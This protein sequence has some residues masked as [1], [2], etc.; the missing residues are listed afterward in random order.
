MLID[1][2]DY[3]SRGM[4]PCL[5]FLK[6][7]YQDLNSIPNSQKEPRVPAPGGLTP[8]SGLSGWLHSQAKLT[9]IHIH[10]ILKNNLDCFL[11]EGG[12]E[13]ERESR[14]SSLKQHLPRLW[15]HPPPRHQ[16][17]LTQKKSRS[18]SGKE[19]PAPASNSF[20]LPSRSHRAPLP[21]L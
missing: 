5:T 6:T 14:T 1:L 21:N 16:G 19:P 8:S 2:A 17:P 15:T 18:R 7:W 4:V 9:S 3:N 13:R 12:R 20:P 10:V 11:N